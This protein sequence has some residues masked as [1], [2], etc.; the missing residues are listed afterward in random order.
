MTASGFGTTP[1]STT[2]FPTGEI[3]FQAISSPSSQAGSHHINRYEGQETRLLSAM[4]VRGPRC[5]PENLFARTQARLLADDADRETSLRIPV[6]ACG[7]RRTYCL[8]AVE[9]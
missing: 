8:G 5:L 2:P 6:F 7:A 3:H 4:S 1:D 9:H